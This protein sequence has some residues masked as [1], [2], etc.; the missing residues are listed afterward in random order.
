MKVTCKNISVVMTVIYAIAITIIMLHAFSFKYEWYYSIAPLWFLAIGPMVLVMLF[1]SLFKI[2]AS[3]IVL[4]IVQAIIFTISLHGYYD[5][6]YVH[7]DA[8]NGL[9]FIIFPVLE[10]A[11]IFIVCIVIWFFEKI[12]SAKK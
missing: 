12:K 8:L 3:K 6:F 9:L 4:I 11:L 1:L 5:A 10:F 2:T 7:L